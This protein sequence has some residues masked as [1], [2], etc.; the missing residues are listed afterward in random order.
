MLTKRKR[1]E[2]M[3]LKEYVKHKRPIASG[4]TKSAIL[5]YNISVDDDI[6]EYKNFRSV[7]LKTR[8]GI[9]KLIKKFKNKKYYNN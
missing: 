3:T 4:R 1:G 2:K 7:G 9:E 8:K 5:N 6:M